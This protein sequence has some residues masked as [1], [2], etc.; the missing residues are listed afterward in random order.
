MLPEMRSNAY[1][2]LT[3]AL[4]NAFRGFP[5]M[6]SDASSRLTNAP[7]DAFNKFP[8]SLQTL[9]EMPSQASRVRELL[10]EAS[11]MLTNSDTDSVRGLLEANKCCQRC[12]QRLPGCKQIF[13][14][15]PSEDF[16]MHT[17]HSEMPSEASRRPMH[18]PSD[19]KLLD[20]SAV[21]ASAVL[22]VIRSLYHPC[23]AR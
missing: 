18:A 19:S 2:K 16:R 7:R 21:A 22:C 1:R 6:P 4:R 8:G 5:K 20:P 23:I 13:L 10:S 3:G 9:P 15:M 17:M 14:E 12:R 11:S